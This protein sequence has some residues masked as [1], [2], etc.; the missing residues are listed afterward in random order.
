VGKINKEFKEAFDELAKDL[1]EHKSVSAG[2]HKSKQNKVL[3]VATLHD[4][5]RSLELIF[6]GLHVVSYDSRDNSLFLGFCGFS[7]Y[8]ATKELLNTF[9]PKGYRF[10]S[11]NFIGYAETPTAR[12]SQCFTIYHYL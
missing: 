6:H 3:R 9:C 11:K 12:F 7:H 8:R 2:I 10:Y 4:G 5:T 1:R